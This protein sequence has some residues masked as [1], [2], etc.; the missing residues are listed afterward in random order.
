[1]K[2]V[3]FILAAVLMI[4][5]CQQAP[6]TAY[7]QNEKVFKEYKGLKEQEEIFKKQQETFVKKYDSLLKVWQ[8]EVMDFQQNVK[9]MSSKQ[10][11]KK[12]QEL[13]RKQQ[14]LQQMQQQEGAK[15]T[16][17]MQQKS[18]SI[19]K[20]VYDFF[21]DYGKKNGYEYI[22]GK[23][24]NGSL[25]Y[26]KADKDITEEVIKALNAEYDKTKK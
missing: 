6:K 7:V 2:K 9:K 3:L 16:A 24:N 11:Q 13:Y 15:I 17:E 21:A 18:D 5:S 25:M 14:M 1:M 12:D 10:A 22:F 19:T 23:N 20:V 26:G 8:Q 4:S